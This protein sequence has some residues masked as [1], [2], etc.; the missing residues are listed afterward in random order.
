MA[1]I[2]P[3]PAENKT[4]RRKLHNALRIDMTPMVDLGFLLITFFI[5]TT[6]LSAPKVTHLIMPAEDGPP[7][8]IPESKTLTVLL[9]A[10]NKVYA[11]EGLWEDAI[12]NNR[13]MTTNYH[14]SDGLGKLIRDKQKRLDV[15]D[16]KQHRNSLV[17]V[18]KPLPVSSYKN[19]ID[20]LD[21][22]I[23]NDVK[24][25]VIDKPSMAESFHFEKRS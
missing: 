23:I 15:L 21:E 4:T 3:Q 20:A 17:L 13:I 5:F 16:Q 2:E 8:P 10:E 1:N 11:Y 14:I 22:T 24:K 12:Q 6:T 19:V 7:M 25:F 9:G 18:I